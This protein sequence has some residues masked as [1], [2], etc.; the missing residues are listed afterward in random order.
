M[1]QKEIQKQIDEYTKFLEEVGNDKYTL[2]FIDT[3]RLSENKCLSIPTD[4]ITKEEILY[5]IHKRMDMLKEELKR[6]EF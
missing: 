4:I 1:T 5:R 3:V 2:V 6:L